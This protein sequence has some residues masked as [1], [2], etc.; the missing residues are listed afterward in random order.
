MSSVDSSTAGAARAGIAIGSAV[1]THRIPARNVRSPAPAMQVAAA[2][3]HED[4]TACGIA[5]ITS[6]V[7]SKGVPD[8]S[9]GLLPPDAAGLLSLGENLSCV[10][11]IAPVSERRA[12][13]G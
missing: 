9:R 4:V 5:E 7:Q 8:R 6:T 1:A 10:Q 13:F 12:A 3:L 2:E 11:V